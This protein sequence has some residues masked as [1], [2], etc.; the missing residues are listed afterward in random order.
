MTCDGGNR[1]G[2]GLSCSS[3]SSSST[4]QT[5]G[6][7]EIKRIEQDDDHDDEDDYEDEA[8]SGGHSARRVL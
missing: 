3:S 7:W 2:L 8:E 6:A 5:P 4:L 1:L